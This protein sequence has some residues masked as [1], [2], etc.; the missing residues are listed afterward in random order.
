MAN[1]GRLA[2]AVGISFNADLAKPAKRSFNNSCVASSSL[3][4][5]STSEVRR[6][7]T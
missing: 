7:L 2:P 6:L 1:R 3:F 4:F 5:P